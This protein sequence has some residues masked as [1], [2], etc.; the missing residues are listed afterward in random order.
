MVPDKNGSPHLDGSQQTDDVER[1]YLDS[2]HVRFGLGLPRI[3]VAMKPLP[4]IT[5]WHFDARIHSQRSFE[6]LSTRKRKVIVDFVYD[7][8]IEKKTEIYGDRT[9]HCTDAVTV[10]WWFPG[11]AR[12]PWRITYKRTH[13]RLRFSRGAIERL[14][15]QNK[16]GEGSLPTSSKENTCCAGSSHSSVKVT[17]FLRSGGEEDPSI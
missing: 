4:K 1:R 3:T 6:L 12:I 16:T 2:I 14:Q 13:I 9:N 7:V 15:L 11:P 8:I 5:R 17:R 10:P